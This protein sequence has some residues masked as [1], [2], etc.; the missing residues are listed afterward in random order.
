[1]DN[2]STYRPLSPVLRDLGLSCLGAGE[3]G[4]TSLLQEQETFL[5]CTGLHQPGPGLVPAWRDWEKVS[6]PP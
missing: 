6:A 2:W 5:L 3:Q 4:G 1:M